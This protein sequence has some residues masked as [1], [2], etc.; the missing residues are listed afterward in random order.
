MLEYVIRRLGHSVIVLF[1][2]TLIGFFITH[3]L[4]GDPTGVILG[5]TA[6]PEAVAA[7]REEIGLDDPLWKQY[8]DWL[9]KTLQLDL[10]NTFRSGLDVREELLTRLAPT[11]QLGTMSFILSFTLA[12]I[13][14]SLAASKRNSWIDMF[15]RGVGVVGIAT[16]NF[17]LGMVLII[18]VSVKLGWLPAFGYVPFFEDPVENMKRMIMPIFAISISQLAVTVRMV[19]GSMIEVLS[20]DYIRTAR[21]KGLAARLIFYRHALRNAMIPVCT[22]AGI[23]I[24]HILGGSAVVETIFAIPGVGRFTAESVQAH[25]YNV[26]QAVMLLAGISIVSANLLVD[27]AYGWLDPRIRLAGR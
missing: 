22:V 5:D 14:G 18:L 25:E 21:A 17:W 9:T 2:V 24:G 10:G 3:V 6:S 23:Q 19:R 16:P 27:L 1:I 20:Q 7:L 13:L 8:T 15:A 12:I 11:I 4:P 26:V